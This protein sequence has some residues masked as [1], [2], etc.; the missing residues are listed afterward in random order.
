VYGAVRLEQLGIPGVLSIARGFE[1]DANTAADVNGMPVLRMVV[2]PGY[3]W[4]RQSRE[5]KKSLAEAS[6]KELVDGLLRPLSVEEMKPDQKRASAAPIEVV[7]ESRE[8]LL[9]DFNEL[10]LKNRWG[11]GLPLV[12]PTPDRLR[13]MLSGTSRRTDEVIGKVAPGKGLATIEKIAINAVMAGAR[14]EYLPVIV[15]AMEGL[16]DE[17]FDLL[18][19]QASTGN[20]TLAV[21][22]SG[23][24]AKEIGMNSGVGY[25]GHGWR[26]NNTIGRALRLCLINLGHVWPGIN[27][28]ASVGR[29]SPHTFYTFAEN[30]DLSPWPPYHTDRGFSEGESCVA[31]ST[32]GGYGG[33]GIQHLTGPSAKEI[34]QDLVRGIGEN[35]RRLFSLFRR[36]T[37][38]PMAHWSKHIITLYPEAA[39]QLSEMGFT[40]ERLADYIYERTSV[41][42]EEFTP[43][44]TRSLRDRIEGT[45]EGHMLYAD[46][47]PPDRL[48]VFQEALRPGGKI[49]VLITPK[50][51]H[52]VVAGGGG[53]VP[54]NVVWFSYIKAVY[55]WTSHQVR[56]IRGAALTRAGR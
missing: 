47:I 17:D 19:P 54:G 32:V 40:R 2:V 13:W 43:D 53:G 23:P 1:D 10:F 31:V 29:P 51:I 38:N 33:F 39:A 20:F 4:G 28:M 55:R 52:V 3:V 36:G 37:A 12:P 50:D 16:T 9:E 22:V 5:A 6:Y 26:S 34:L 24:I 46:M 15:A 18:H 21:I 42:F 8:T 27:D 44:E 41:P 14:P 45:I 49:P 48:S 56:A 7:S 25:L 11:D 35:R 30:S